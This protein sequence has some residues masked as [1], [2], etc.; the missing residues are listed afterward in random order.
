MS[1]ANFKMLRSDRK[2]TARITQSPARRDPK[3]KKKEGDHLDL[4]HLHG[5]DH[6]GVRP[7]DPGSGREQPRHTAAGGGWKLDGGTG[8]LTNW[9]IISIWDYLLWMFYMVATPTCVIF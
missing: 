4:R 5:S 2:G 9:F 6:R 7:A 1:C 8:D 3:E